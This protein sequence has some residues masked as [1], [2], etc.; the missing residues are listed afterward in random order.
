MALLIFSE[1]IYRFFLVQRED[2]FSKEKIILDSLVAQWDFQKQHD[3]TSLPERDKFKFDPN[4]ATED[5]LLALGFPGNLVQR[6]L[7][8]RSKMGKFSIKSDVMKIYGMDSAL[9]TELVPFINLPEKKNF[10]TATRKDKTDI[11]KKPE[12][13]L[14]NL[15]LAD[16]AQ[17]KSIYGI[18]PVL[19]NRIVEYRIKLGGFISS[20]QLS[21][22]YGLDTAVINRLNNKSFIPENFIPNQLNINQADEKTM[23]AHPYIKF[24][25]AKAII[26]YRFQ[27][28]NFKTIDDLTH[29]KTLKPETIEKLRPYLTF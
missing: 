24:K 21:E 19:A 27:H 29:I 16:T 2:D 3:S 9:Y 28:G 12:I 6:I 4:T 13:P 17:L 25:P 10:V 11:Y 26:T 7:N 5:D 14:F 18:G 8:Y 1:P 15:N 23:A 20:Q 22:V